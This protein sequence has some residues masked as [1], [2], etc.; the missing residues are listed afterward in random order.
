MGAISQPLSFE[1]AWPSAACDVDD[2]RM[3]WRDA[4]DDLR[5]AHHAWRESSRADRRDAFYAVV[6]AADREAIAAETLSR[7]TRASSRLSPQA[8]PTS[9]SQGR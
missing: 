8:T 1:A 5:L 9:T 6:A 3:A 7:I 2:V 4:C